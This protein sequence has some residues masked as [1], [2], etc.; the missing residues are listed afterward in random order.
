MRS[1][2]PRRKTPARPVPGTAARMMEAGNRGAGGILV[3]RCDRTLGLLCALF[4]EL[5]KS[6]S[7]CTWPCLYPGYREY[8]VTTR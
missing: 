2:S 5:D 4:P 8:A 3:R 1:R 7:R 6:I